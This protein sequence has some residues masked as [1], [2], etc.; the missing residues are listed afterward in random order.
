MPAIM[1]FGFTYMFG[2]WL[3]P[4][5][6]GFCFIVYSLNLLLIIVYT[7]FRYIKLQ[8]F[9]HSE[10]LQAGGIEEAEMRRTFNM[11]IGMV[12]VVSSEASQRILAE[13]HAGD[14]AYLIGEVINGEGVQ[15]A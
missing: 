1:H 6:S 8:H 10:L 5:P 13:S 11:C 15:F 7:N 4:K 3:S 12:L 14:P 9:D 2:H